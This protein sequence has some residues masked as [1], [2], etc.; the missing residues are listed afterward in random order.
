MKPPF[1]WKKYL[2][3][4]GS[5]LGLALLIRQGILGRSSLVLF[6]SSR[7]AIQNAGFALLTSILAMG[8]PIL[9]FHLLLRGAGVVL[10]LRA[11]VRRYTFTFLP[12]YLPGSVWGYIS[13]G[14][15]LHRE[16][17]VQYAVSS[18]VSFFELAAS[19][20]TC[21]ACAGSLGLASG[22]LPIFMYLLLWGALFLGIIFAANFLTSRAHTFPPAS[23]WK[24]WLPSQCMQVRMWLAAVGL[25]GIHWILCGLALS[26]IIQAGASAGLASNIGVL[27]KCYAGAWLIGFFTL[28]A[29]AGMGF[30]EAALAGLLILL[31]GIAAPVA[32]ACALGLRLVFVLAELIWTLVG[33]TMQPSPHN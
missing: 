30:R 26:F 32:A 10:P 18:S 6:F 31:T 20:S 12:R 29:P 23:I 21:V 8:I 27:V 9:A 17:S 2:S 33:W 5:L 13:R 7:S 16:L 11:I 1:L 4:F 3:I 24:R 25:Y 22:S 28:I 15:W 14:E 19:L